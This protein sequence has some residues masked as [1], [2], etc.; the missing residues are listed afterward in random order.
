MPDILSV[1]KKAAVVK[2]AGKLVAVAA[3]SG[4]ALV[5]IF[6]AL[7]SYGMIGNT[8]SHQSIGNLGAA[9]VGLRP[10]VDTAASIGDTVHYAATVTDRN[11][12]ILV[13]ARPTWTTGDSTVAIVRP[14]GS[15]IARGPGKT[16]VSV[17]V[18]KLV[19]HSRI[20][21]QQRVATVEVAVGGGDSVVTIPEGSHLQL[22]ARA[23]D[24]RGYRIAGVVPS[25]HIDD[26][27]VAAVDTAG[28]LTGR[29][30]GRT[31]V[32]AKVD[33]VSGRAGVSVV[34][35]ASAIALVAGSSQRA[36]AGMALPQ[37]VVVRATNRRGAPAAGKLVTFRL[38]D[39]QGSVEPTTVRTDADGRARATWTL[40][41]YPGRQWL[42]ASV[43]N[44]DSALTVVAEADPVASNTRVAVLADQLTGRAGEALA[45]SIGIRVTDSIGR[46]LPDVPV[47]WVAVDGTVE[48][49]SSRTDSLGVARA[50]WKLARRT[51]TQR[52]RAQVGSGPGSRDI[53]A[54]TVTATALAGA[55]AAVVVESG[56][57]Q[58]AAAGADL[59]RPIVVRV[60]DATGNGVS[61]AKLDLAASG[62]SVPDSV[63]RTDSLGVARTGW[64]LGRSAGAYTLAIH[65]EGVK[66]V[67]KVAAQAKPAAP[68]N[69]SFDDVPGRVKGGKSAARTKRLYALVTDLYGNPV[70]DAKVSFSVTS[71]TVTPARAVS[72]ARGRAALTWKLGAKPGEQ[73]LTGAVRATD[74]R[75][76][77]AT[78]VAGREP[79]AKM[80][81]L[82]SAAR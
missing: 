11:G 21:V 65:A 16:V 75:G 76:Q 43:E 22:K 40:G 61:G 18:G 12:S 13:G 10:S 15:V 82:K 6:S 78:E 71:G 39:G 38:T 34:T 30:A 31:V 79:A 17:V 45:D 14:D 73:I 19:A 64:T 42:F 56:D 62:G 35:P 47:R 63:L 80:A 27:T 36:V 46:I 53:P 7:Y 32:T 41:A 77:Y 66:K 37:A 9:W 33:A 24:A 59:P 50:Q 60:V 52:A 51:G 3:S 48:T 8:E 20:L 55:P 26:S 68:A 28:A 57:N 74:V 44:V 69:L 4:A 2:H 5:T 49:Q 58:R 72:D 1:T 23:L 29:N 70:P 25:W 81:S 54:I 67:I